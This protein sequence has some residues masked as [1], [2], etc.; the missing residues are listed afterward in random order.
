MHH[1]EEIRNAGYELPSV[2]QIEVMFLLLPSVQ[3]LSL[4][5]LVTPLP[6]TNRNSQI[7]QREQHR[8]TGI[9]P[10]CPRKDG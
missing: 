6:S 2:N 8:R 9:L 3:H 1:I 10:Y 4:F 5:L 7:L